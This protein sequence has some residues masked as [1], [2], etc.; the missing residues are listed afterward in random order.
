MIDY[1]QENF[2]LFNQINSKLI[3]QCGAA[4]P[5]VSHHFSKLECTEQYFVHEVLQIFCAR[6]S[7]D[8]GRP[9]RI[10]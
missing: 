6:R 2:Q 7:A 8:S 9:L 10:E 3:Y 4:H 1:Q 5:R